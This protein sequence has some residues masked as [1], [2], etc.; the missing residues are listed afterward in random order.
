MSLFANITSWPPLGQITFLKRRRGTPGKV[1]DDKIRF[2]V[3]LES[4]CSFP[5][6]PWNISLWHSIH[7][8]DEW[9][10]LELQKS[11]PS[12]VP[13]A[14]SEKAEKEYFRYVFV[15]EIP[16]PRDGKRA[17]FTIKYRTDA[18]AQWQWVNEKFGTK[19]GEIIIEPQDMP[20]KWSPHCLEKYLHSLNNDLDIMP[21]QSEAPGALLWSIVGTVGP[22]VNGESTTA[23]VVLGT[24]KEF[25]RTF[26]IVRIW[27]PWLAP[28][29]GTASFDL[30]EESILSSFVY[31]DGIILVLLAVSGIDDVLTVFRSGKEGEVIVCSQND[32]DHKAKT[33][34]LAATASSFEIAMAAVIYEARKMIRSYSTVSHD[35][36]SPSGDKNTIQEKIGD[37]PKAQWL[38]EWYDGLSYCTW[39][40]LGQNL[41]E[42]KILNA[43][44]LLKENGIGISNLII[45]DGWQSLDNEGQSQFKQGM[46]RF[47]ANE[48]G[49]PH[50]LRHTVSRVRQENPNIR[51][52]AVWHALMGY[53]GGISPNGDIAAKYKTSEI[54]RT[55]KMADSKTV[56]ID[57]DDIS[58]FYNDFYSFLSSAGVDSVKADAQYFLD[59]L[60]DA[61]TRRRCMTT[62]QDSWIISILRHFQARAISCMS[63]I[64]QIM[65]HS[66]LLS[67]KPRLLLRN[68][69]D[70]FPDV[71]ASHTWHIFCNAHN[72]LLTKYL[73]VIPDWDMFQT[74]HPYSSFHAAA[75]CVSG[76]AI[77]IT[78]DPGKHDL[79]LID[80]MTAPTSR[81][82]RVILRPSVVGYTRDVYNNYNEGCM[83]KIGSF[84]G[85]ARTGSGI[86]GLFN[87]ASREVSSLISVSEFPGILPNNDKEY[88]IRAH[89]TGKI[90][91]AMRPSD[92]HSMVSVTLGL[93]RWE[94]LTVYP[95][96]AFNIPTKGK[97]LTPKASPQVK[98]AVLG[99]LG[100]MTGVAAILGSDISIIPGNTLR[101]DIT[102]KALGILGLWI[103]DLV[104]R[105][106]MENFMVLLHGQ[107]VP[108]ET[109]QKGVHDQA[110]VLSIDILSAWQAMGLDSGWSNEVSVQILMM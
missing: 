89:N 102:L 106:V 71:E 22:A 42:E 43:L 17:A 40:A 64:P 33:Q 53:W 62:Y 11:P 32:N 92:I 72:N 50:G 109:V 59:I 69:D 46:T 34:V 2:T 97:P 101:F 24:P 65:F 96:Y 63:Q 75:R 41:T 13:M 1:E 105:E 73:N 90:T 36:P 18:G 76:G 57:P 45:D 84:T 100:K 26:S 27:T 14:M 44:R 52:I 60:K 49:F 30:K 20:S 68:S 3:V 79:G 70:F 91:Q 82:D 103:S 21:R 29:H 104:G 108:I 35:I 88:V 99:L 56:I 15:A 23:S 7:G 67:N 5:E 6:Q 81:G 87:I 107:A 77:Y 48:Q 16:F 110:C 31:Q 37:E 38:S 55:D 4:S 58:R 85:R 93:K 61:N 9:A 95:V 12:V 86:L 94:I 66:Q 83:L 8:G 25:V 51:H 54:E 78:D 28:R 98:V 39:N 47:E 80:Q 74:R 10:E 19:N